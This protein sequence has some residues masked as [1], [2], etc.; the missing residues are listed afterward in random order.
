MLALVVVFGNVQWNLK[1]GRRGVVESGAKQNSTESK[2]RYVLKNIR[3]FD[4]VGRGL[5][6]DEGG[7]AG[8]Q[9]TRHRKGVEV[10][11]AE[12]ADNDG[13]GIPDIASGDLFSLRGS[14]TG[15]G[16]WK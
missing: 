10:L 16:P 4:S 9:D 12:S 7:V 14:V 2:A 3:D 1:I 6:P 8:H 11:S 5:S 13:P 15:T